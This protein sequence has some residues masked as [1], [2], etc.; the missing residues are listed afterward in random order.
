MSPPTILLA[1]QLSGVTIFSIKKRHVTQEQ[2]S[3]GIVIAW[4]YEGG[5]EHVEP[6]R[7][8]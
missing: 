4:R 7:F 1:L 8:S 5:D 2:M 6:A 3:I